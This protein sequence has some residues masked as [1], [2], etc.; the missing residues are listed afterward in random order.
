MEQNPSWEANSR[1]ASE[2]FPRLLW[3]PK[4]HFCV[5]KSL[6]LVPILRQMNPVHT[7]PTLFP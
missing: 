3:N 6:A 1:S 4:V 5:H 7:F 2:T